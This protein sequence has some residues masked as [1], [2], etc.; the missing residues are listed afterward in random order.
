MS[1][2][3]D[4]MESLE[5]TLRAHEAERTQGQAVVSRP[6]A[7]PVRWNMVVGC[8]GTSSSV[9]K[10]CMARGAWFER[11][12]LDNGALKLKDPTK[13]RLLEARLMDPL[14]VG[15][16]SDVEVAPLSDLFSGELNN[17]QLDQIFTVM[18]IAT[19]HRF[20]VTTKFPDHAAEYIQRLKGGRTAVRAPIKWPLAN[21]FL[22]VSVEDQASY[23]TRVAAL[24]KV[25]SANRYLVF[26]P[27]E[28]AI[29]ERRVLLPHGDQFDPFTGFVYEDQGGG[30]FAKTPS[31]TLQF[32]PLSWILI[33][34]ALHKGGL[35]PH[36]DWVR[37][38]MV[39]AQALNIPVWFKG[40]GRFAPT[41]RPNRDEDETLLM[42]NSDGTARGRGVGSKTNFLSDSMDGEASVFFTRRAPP[43]QID[44]IDGH[45]V[46]ERIAGP[47][48]RTQPGMQTGEIEALREHLRTSRP[49]GAKPA[50]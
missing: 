1:D 7:M 24:A 5:R 23:N 35:P 33:G 34:G 22:G 10:H 39:A 4:L 16:P 12:A 42:L 28:S 6:R 29:S 27:L 3:N 47:A 26:E 49:A 15:K 41:A 32:P 40:W 19:Q 46:R 13:A 20:F 9:C 17:K 2:F 48:A 36:P 18:K 25:D 44:L 8:K 31:P 38:L 21:V 14:R 11:F 45:S 50:K 37:S 43:D 30:K